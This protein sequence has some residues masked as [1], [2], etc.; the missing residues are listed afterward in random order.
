[1]FLALICKLCLWSFKQYT[2][3]KLYGFKKIW[4]CENLHT[5]KNED[6]KEME[7]HC[8]FAGEILFF[9]PLGN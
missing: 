4:Y 7:Q 8:P 3:N 6:R 9:G 5:K 2:R 1:M